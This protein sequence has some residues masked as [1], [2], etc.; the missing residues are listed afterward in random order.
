MEKWTV[1]SGYSSLDEALAADDFD[2]AS[3]CSPTGT[4]LAALTRLAASSVKA[5]FVEKPLDGDA[6]GARKI[7]ER[8]AAKAVPVAVNFTRRFDPAMHLLRSEIAEGRHGTLRRVCG[9]YCRGIVNNGSHMLDLVGFLTGMRPRLVSTGPALEDGVRGDP[10]VSASLDLRQSPFD[11]I[12][13]DG[14]DFARFELELA[15]SRGIVALENGGQL[16]RRRPVEGGAFPGTK[17]AA[18]GVWEC[19]GYGEAMLRAL[20]ELKDW[21]RTRKLSSDIETASPSIALAD[22][23]RRAARTPAIAMPCGGERSA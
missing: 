14:R 21:S 8:F 9:W 18:Q 20:D 2:I 17:S 10:T 5:V 19:T 11:L 16:I 3:V 1:A 15:F 12:G 6:N 23:I 22:Q 4:H 13:C 7:A